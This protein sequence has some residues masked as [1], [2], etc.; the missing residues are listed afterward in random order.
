VDKQ[1]ST[2]TATK[3]YVDNQYLNWYTLSS[4]AIALWKTENYGMKDQVIGKKTEECS[5]EIPPGMLL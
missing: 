3:K 2:T 5:S 1:T 4:W